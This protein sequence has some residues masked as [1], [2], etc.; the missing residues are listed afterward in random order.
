MSE[1]ERPDRWW[2][3]QGHVRD[4][5]EMDWHGWHLQCQPCSRGWEWSV[6]G[7]TI[8]K[9]GVRKTFYDA[10]VAAEV[11]FVGH[12]KKVNPIDFGTWLE[13]VDKYTGWSLPAPHD[14]PFY[15]G[16]YWQQWYLQC[17]KCIDTGWK[18]TVRGLGKAE[19]CSGT[20]IDLETAKTSA[21]E[22]FRDVLRKERL[23]HKLL[24][25]NRWLTKQT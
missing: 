16:L 11:W 15:W 23:G 25:F 13:S 3:Q 5:W 18:W 20:A 9:R 7:K 17:G 21:V 2:Y 1:Q 14:L 12:V 24:E 8:L 19:I 4:R 6:H 10:W 22:A